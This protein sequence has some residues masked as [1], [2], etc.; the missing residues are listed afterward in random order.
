MFMLMTL[1][2]ASGAGAQ[3]SCGSLANAVGPWDYR[4]ASQQRRELVELYHFRLDV[5][6]LAP[7]RSPIS[8]GAD[9]SY[10][11]RAF[12]NHPRALISMANLG[13]REKRRRP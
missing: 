7:G 10:T 12:P 2:G 4:T 8:I 13:Q 9:I 3:E 1:L 5:E 6:T 11:L